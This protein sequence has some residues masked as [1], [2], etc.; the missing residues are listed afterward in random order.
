M[1]SWAQDNTRQH[2]FAVNTI[3]F[4]LTQEGSTTH[5]LMDSIK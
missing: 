4:A 3:I 2:Q 5:R 1:K